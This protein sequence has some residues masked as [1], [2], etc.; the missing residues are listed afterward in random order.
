MRFLFIFSL[1]C[2]LI[3]LGGNRTYS[4]SDLPSHLL[5]RNRS[6]QATDSK[7]KFSSSTATTF[8]HTGKLHPHLQPMS[9]ADADAEDGPSGKATKQTRRRALLLTEGYI[10]DG[11]SSRYSPPADDIPLHG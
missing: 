1:M 2:M 7:T 3:A 11:Q 8:P 10:T 6:I 5:A 9:P 4:R